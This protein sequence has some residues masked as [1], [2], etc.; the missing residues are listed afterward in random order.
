[1][2]GVAPLGSSSTVDTL[3]GI[4][5]GGDIQIFMNS[6][7]GLHQ[8]ITAKDVKSVKQLKGR[9]II[10]GGQKDITALW[11]YAMAKKF[12]L[13]PFKDVDIFSQ[14]RPLTVSLR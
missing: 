14:V 7:D 13:D 12:D 5:G 6:V 4:D 11:W 8:L 10:V 1:M 2:A 9:R 3:R